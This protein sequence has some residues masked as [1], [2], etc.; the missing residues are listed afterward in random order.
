M[1]ENPSPK[2]SLNSCYDESVSLPT[3]SLATEKKTLGKVQN[4][5]GRYFSGLLR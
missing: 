3:V 4:Y 1:Q 2:P 5:K